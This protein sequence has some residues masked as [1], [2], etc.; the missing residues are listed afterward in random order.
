MSVSMPN[1]WRAE[2][3]ISGMPE[4]FCRAAVVVE[5]ITCPTIQSPPNCGLAPIVASRFVHRKRPIAVA[6]LNRANCSRLIDGQVLGCP[7]G[8]IGGV[9]FLQAFFGLPVAAIG[10]R[11]VDFDQFLV[12]RFHGC[13]GKRP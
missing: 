4:T 12:T 3:L 13:P 1:S 8:G 5:A 9:D 6:A 7:Q 2:T 10:I 11:M